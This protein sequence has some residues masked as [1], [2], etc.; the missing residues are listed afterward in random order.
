MDARSRSQVTELHKCLERVRRGGDADHAR[1]MLFG[2]DDIL[3]TSLES[4]P[5]DVDQLQRELTA[6]RDEVRELI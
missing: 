1:I 5:L 4:D 2:L 3:A 6:L